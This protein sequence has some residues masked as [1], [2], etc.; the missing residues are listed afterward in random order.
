MW[1]AE[2]WDGE[3]RR[4]WNR[5]NR[6]FFSSMAERGS[7][8]EESWFM[9]KVGG[10]SGWARDGRYEPIMINASHSCAHPAP[11][12]HSSVT[13]GE[14]LQHLAPHPRPFLWFHIFF[15]LIDIVPF[16]SSFFLLLLPI[17]G[18]LVN[19]VCPCGGQCCC[20]WWS[21]RSRAW[22]NKEARQSPLSCGWAICTC[23]AFPTHRTRLRGRGGD[24]EG[25]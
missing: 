2:T 11:Q 9:S 25:N 24:E 10:M 18:C 20:S 22:G 14:A 12:E 23:Q 1:G 16:A 7:I 19:V 8:I 3:S 4:G 13:R 6:T 17:C 21:Q 5:Y 15:F